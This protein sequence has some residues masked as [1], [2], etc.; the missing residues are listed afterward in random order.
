M[1]YL[2][3]SPCWNPNYVKY[4]V[5]YTSN[6]DRRIQQYEPEISL[7]GTR[8]GE[9][10]DEQILHRRMRLI[11]GLIR[12]FRNEWYVVNKD[13]LSVRN[14]FHESK[15]SVEIAVWKTVTAQKD[16]PKDI[17]DYLFPRYHNIILPGSKTLLR[18][19]IRLNYIRL[20]DESTSTEIK[21]FFKKM[22]LINRVSDRLKYLCEYQCTDDI[23]S[24]ILAQLPDT[25]KVKY[26]YQA[27]GIERCKANSYQPKR[28]SE[29]LGVKFF[30]KSDIAREIYQTFSVDQKIPLS[31]AK[32]ELSG[33][34]QR[35]GYDKTPKATD[36]KEFFEVKEYM[37]TNKSTGKRISGYR[38][39]K[40]LL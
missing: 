8:P 40:K 28:I 34:Y 29:E 37:T 23:K 11:P 36:L 17:F 19:S 7:V 24:V 18:D 15:E 39:I 31:D 12:I 10:M 27:A 1:I 5:G 3:K 32:S 30:S 20:S 4:K 26:L 13:D 33:I 2:L 22:S 21:E 9:L 16:L 25:D 6:L 38:L 14:A 35:I